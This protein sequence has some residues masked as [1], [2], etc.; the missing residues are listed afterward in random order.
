MDFSLYPGKKATAWKNTTGYLQQSTTWV[1]PGIV[2]E[3][4]AIFVAITTFLQPF[5]VGLNT[6]CCD[7]GVF[8]AYKVTT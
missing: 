1:T 7:S 5:P 8:E 4:S 2:T 3:V 6:C